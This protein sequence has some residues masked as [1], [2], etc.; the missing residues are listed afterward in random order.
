MNGATLIFCR[1]TGF[2]RGDKVLDVGSM[3]VNG[4]VRANFLVAGEYIGIDMRPG[5]DVDLVM[6]AEDLPQHFKAG[7]FDIVVCSNALEHME[8]WQDAV[9]A[10]WFVLKEHGNLCIVT[11]TKEKGRHGYPSDY[12]RFTLEEYD[13]V[14]RDQQM[15]KR[16]YLDPRGVGIV[17][18]KLSDSLHFD[19]EPY[20]VP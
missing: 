15:M 2:K 14:F 17:V 12:W 11:P 20:A 16:E 8:R 1:K 7:Y 13:K 3:D 19:I 10:M 9:R 18:K 5:K 4:T 6:C